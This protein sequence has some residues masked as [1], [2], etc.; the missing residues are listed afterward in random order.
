MQAS[1]R[2]FRLLIPESPELFLVSPAWA[3][4]LLEADPFLAEPG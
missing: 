1:Y 2:G 3:D 4:D